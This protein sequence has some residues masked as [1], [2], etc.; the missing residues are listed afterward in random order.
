MQIELK[1]R[2]SATIALCH[3]KTGENLISEA[4][5]LLALKGSLRIDTSTRQKSGGGLFRGI[6]RMLSG[7]SFF[8]NRYSSQGE[9][10][11]WLS[12]PLPGDILVREL[13]G[14]KIVIQGGGFVA[15][16]EEVGID[17]EWQGL[18][19]LFSGESLFWVKAKGSGP[20]IIS[21][22]GEITELQ[23]N[24][25]YLVDTGHIVAFEESLDFKI[26][27]ASRTWF[28]AFLGG[29]GFVCRFKG[30][31]KLWVQ[32]HNARSFGFELTPHLRPRSN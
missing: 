26:S 25:E 13:Q 23:V 1:Y 14:E 3:L 9:S 12:T 4:G 31:G 7:E 18:K 30:R 21:S 2:P 19:S 10:Q 24:G 15:C 16:S 32:S 17:L 11:V 20:V 6:K 22:F 29:E 5:A 28:G 8:L 27:K